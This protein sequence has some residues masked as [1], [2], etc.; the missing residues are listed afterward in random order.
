MRS[1]DEEVGSRDGNSNPSLLDIPISNRSLDEALQGTMST[2]S[3]HVE[4]SL[5]KESFPYRLACFQPCHT[6]SAAM[7]LQQA[8]LAQDYAQLKQPS[9]CL[10]CRMAATRTSRS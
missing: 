9:T 4:D 3:Q 8:A 1:R 5:G 2:M 6:L 7:H 10:P